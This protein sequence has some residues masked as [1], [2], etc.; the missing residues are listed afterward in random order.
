MDP[1]KYLFRSKVSEGPKIINFINLFR[2]NGIKKGGQ[3]WW[4][5]DVSK[6]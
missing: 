2:F 3:V 5:E 6:C 1:I 4:Y